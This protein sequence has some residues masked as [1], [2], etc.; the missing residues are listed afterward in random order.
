MPSPGRQGTLSIHL[1]NEK[2]ILPS[3]TELECPSYNDIFERCPWATGDSICVCRNGSG[4]IYKILYNDIYV[5]LNSVDQTFKDYYWFFDYLK[6]K[7]SS[8]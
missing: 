5:D 1:D 6:S 8:K 7:N 4:E 3:T 2:G